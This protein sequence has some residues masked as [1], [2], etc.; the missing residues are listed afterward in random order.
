MEIGERTSRTRESEVRLVVVLGP[1][2][3]SGQEADSPASD[4]PSPLYSGCDASRISTAYC[5]SALAR[6]VSAASLGHTATTEV[7]PA[8][9]RRC[10]VTSPLPS[11]E[12]GIWLG[13][14]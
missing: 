4:V 1:L 9:G 13:L 11:L 7:W 10:L 5:T 12:T 6:F 14:D 3:Q 2:R 8:R